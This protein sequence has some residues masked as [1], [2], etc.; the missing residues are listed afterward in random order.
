MGFL[1]EYSE[2]F[3]YIGAF[4]AAFLLANLATPVAKKLA[5]KIGAVA[6]PNERTMHKEPMPVGGGMAIYFGFILTV[7]IFVPLTGYGQIEQF[8]GLIIG[9]TVITIVGLLDDIY[10]IQPRVRIIFQVLSALI[11]I[12][13]GTV[14]D[15]VSIPFIE[16]GK[17]EFGMFSP[18]ITLFWIVGITNAVNLLDGLD[19]LAAGIASIASLILLVIAVLFG[20]PIIAG[21]AIVLTASL[22]GACLGFL[23]HNFYPAKIFMGDTGS[24]FLGFSLAVI[25]I[26]TMLKTYTALTLIVAVIILALP[27][28][29]TAFAIIRRTIN[30]RPIHVGD[31]GHL[32]HRLVDR[33]LSHKRA[34]ITL[35]VISGFFG[36]AAILVVMQDFAIALLIIGFILS[37]WLG[38]IAFSR[39]KDKTS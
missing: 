10:D 2:Y 36:I 35:Y 23:P 18:L 19:G 25:S 22:S 6:Y 1:M 14:I 8:A 29:D 13:T 7:L 26:Q 9:A 4:V 11:V 12:Y 27:I 38:D 3:I 32:H 16:A 17:I 5:F 34:V 20:D 21:I 37:V 24:T 28:F 15:S 39:H 33:G 31:R 30:R